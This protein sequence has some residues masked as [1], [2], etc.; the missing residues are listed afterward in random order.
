LSSYALVNA[1]LGLSFDQRRG[2]IGFRPARAGDATYFWSA[3]RGWGEIAFRGAGAV[4]SVKG[5][6]LA[7]SALNLPT[8][9]GRAMV[10][11][12]TV[13]RDGD[14]ILL[15]ETRKLAA[16]DFLTIEVDASGAA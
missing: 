12:V 10:D 16:G 11:G 14:A 13:E 6:E 8:L 4:L 9:P 1:W 2:E 3:G 5:G 7:I 15:G